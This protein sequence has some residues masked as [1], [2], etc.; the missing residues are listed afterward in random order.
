MLTIETLVIGAGVVGLATAR[1]LVRQGYQ[2]AIL[3]Q[4]PQLGGGISSR[5]SEV[6]HAGLYYPTNSLKART[7]LRG[8]ALL[9]QYC[10]RRQIPHRR[11]GKLVFASA[12]QQDDIDA[13]YANAVHN[14]VDNIQRLSQR[15][16]NTNEP[17]LSANSGLLSANSGII[18]S[19]QLMNSLSQEATQQGALLC[20]NHKVIKID[21]A[22]NHF[23]LVIDGPSGRFDLSCRQLVNA[24][25]LNGVSLANAIGTPSPKD[26]QPYRLG[27]AKGN[28]FSLLSQSPTSRLIYPLPESHGL[29]IH[30]TLDLAGRA[31][32]GPDVEWIKCAE[33]PNFNVS[34]QRKSRFESAIRRYWPNLP[35]AALA[36][37]YA[38]IR[39]KLYQGNTQHTDFLIETSEQHG[40]K[41]LV[42]L[43][44]IESPG[45]TAALALAEEVVD[46]L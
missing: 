36:P 16:L 19:A 11:C 39:P 38:G 30:L 41:G 29:G 33:P 44:G 46:A 4:Q 3:E 43:L 31:R 26:T 21:T 2:V 18:D 10:K 25:G 24:A 45:L 42:N 35:A 5:S 7:C 1:E 32:F 27:L 37:D 28:Y 40:M 34:T 22:D 13:L 6:I 17:W 9:Y 8:N 14:G 12:M 15:W 20:L 23:Q